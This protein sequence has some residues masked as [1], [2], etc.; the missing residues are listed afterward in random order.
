MTAMTARVTAVSS[1]GTYS[2]SK[3]NRAGTTL[4]AGLGVEDDVPA[5]AAS[6]TGSA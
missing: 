1:N 3:P 6:G 2:F 5:G 4:L